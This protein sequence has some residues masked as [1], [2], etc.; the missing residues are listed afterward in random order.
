[1]KGESK[2]SWLKVHL[3][4]PRSPPHCSR[5]PWILGHESS[6]QCHPKRSFPLHSLDRRSDSLDARSDRERAPPE[7]CPEKTRRQKIV[8]L[9]LL[10]RRQ[11]KLLN[12]N[13][14]NTVI[15]VSF[16]DLA[17]DFWF[18]LFFILVRFRHCERSVGFELSRICLS[19]ANQRDDPEWL[20]I[21][22]L[23]FMMSRWLSGI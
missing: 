22:G 13:Y 8:P 4:E 3:E 16:R 17:F 11:R 7:P 12:S 1:M 18:A 5:I 14:N 15:K 9:I 21:G 19:M 20:R 23:F 2:N 6:S 10:L